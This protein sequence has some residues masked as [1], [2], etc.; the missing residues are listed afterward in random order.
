MAPFDETSL[1]ADVLQV[2]DEFPE[3]Q[4]AEFIDSGANGY[5]LTGMHTKL[6]K[7]VALKVYYHEA[8]E[9]DQE[10][11]LI[12]GIMH[13]NVMRV[14]D[15]RSLSPTCSF[16][17]TPCA[18]YGDL[19]S[20]LG[21][22]RISTAF[23]YQL[24]TQLLSG[25]AALHESK[26]VHRDVKPENLLIHDETLL[27]ADFGSVRRVAED[28]GVAPASRHSVLY[29]PPEAIGSSP[30][31]DFSCDTYQAGLVGFLLFGG[32]LGNDLERYLNASQRR[33]LAALKAAGDVFAISRYVDGCVENRITRGSLIDWASLPQYVPSAITR[34]LKRATK[35]A[36]Y[37]T[38]SEFLFELQRAGVGIPNWIQQGDTWVLM[39]WRGRDYRLSGLNGNVAVHKR[40]AGKTK[41][42]ADN[43]LSGGDLR[44][45][46]GRLSSQLGLA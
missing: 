25:L 4:P 42:I 6:R 21:Q 27:I 2:L 39:D 35:G 8:S 7:R 41:F 15:A 32:S 26:L 40:A 28:T 20:H 33:R 17:M 43:Q 16:F 1:P 45:V 44:T 46:Y 29:R 11:A 22:Y 3:F 13:D 23:A 36:R 5:V 18:N 38:C 19:A 37:D 12:A 34:V 24:L 10:P 14:H 30:Y 9:V 31:F